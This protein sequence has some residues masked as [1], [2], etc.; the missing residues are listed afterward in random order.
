MSARI[1]QQERA[2]E[3]KIKNNS[4][5]FELRLPTEFPDRFPLP[6]LQ[7]WI[8]TQFG[9]NQQIEAL[10]RIAET[11]EAELTPEEKPW[12]LFADQFVVFSP[13]VMTS[14]LPRLRDLSSVSR[15]LRTKDG[16]S[17]ERENSTDSSSTWD[18]SNPGKDVTYNQVWPR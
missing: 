2:N 11:P 8:P 17:M 9:L 7:S 12:K 6:D 1:D 18:S 16:L 3:I 10:M 14:T 4:K 15:L 5:P 13:D